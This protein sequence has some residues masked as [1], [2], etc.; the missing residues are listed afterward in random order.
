MDAPARQG[1]PIATTQVRS[2]CRLCPAYCGILVTRDRD[3]VVAVQGDREHPLSQGYTC[4]KG[5]A[6]GELHHDPSRLDGPLLRRNGRLEPVSW[7]ELVDDLATRVSGILEGHGPGAVGVYFG[8]HATF[9][10]NLY[11]AGAALLKK[12]GSPSKYTSGTVDAPSYPLV[13]RLMAGVGWLFHS[14]DFEQATMTLLLGTNPVVSHTAHMNAFPNPT[15]RI[16]ELARRGEVWVIDARATETARIATRHLAPR[17]GTD[18]ALLA[19]LIRE[20]LRDGAD[21]EYLARHARNVDELAAAVE[22]FDLD[23]AAQVTDLAPNDLAD[24]LAAVRRHGRLAL[25]TGTGTSMAPAANLTQWFAVA[26]LAVT[27]SLERPRGVWFNPGFVQGLDRRP[28]LPEGPPQ[29]GPPSRPELPRQGG[30]Y[31]AIGMIDELEAGNLRALFVLGGNLLAALPDAPRVRAAL[32]RTPVVVVSDVQRGEMTELATHA[33][34]AAGPLERAD[35]PHFSDCLAPALAAQYTPAVVPVGADRRP[36]WWP[37][38]ALAERLDASI[39]PDG[40]TLE[41]A[42]DDDLLRLRVRPSARATFDELKAAGT[43]LVEE[44]RAFGWVERNVL[45]DGRWNLAPEPLVRQLETVAEVAPLVLIPR[46][47]WRHLN[48]YGCD[49]PGLGKREPADILLHPADAAEAG[50]ADG[51]VVRVESAY[52]SLQGIAR[53]DDS[54]RRGAVAIPHGW[55]DPNVSALLSASEGVDALTGMPT[56]CAV[57][58]AISVG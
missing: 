8:T 12:L 39:L 47:Q 38:A 34:A 23:V 52:G 22:R 50:I 5:R 26:L 33:L 53:V 6:L 25:Q 32:A 18:Y 17:P 37:L 7:E 49:L 42:G 9:D 14:I 45:P 56:Y 21:R 27:G 46:R 10:A 54:I 19:F 29:P 16:R 24:L 11:W 40:V 44:D 41:H 20:L 55:A 2:Y 3:R 58:I 28:V 30:E 35:L 31:P 57:P 48:S 1:P 4:P 36:G 15:A 13:R 51:G 43:V